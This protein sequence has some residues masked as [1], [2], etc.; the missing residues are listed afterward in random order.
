M[1]DKHLTIIRKTG[2]FLV[3]GIFAIIAFF[4]TAVIEQATLLD[5]SQEELKSII[6]W[7]NGYTL[8]LLISG[9]LLLVG[10]FPLHEVACMVFNFFG[11][12]EDVPEKWFTFVATVSFFAGS[13]Y[14]IVLFIF[15]IS[16][17]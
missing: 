1:E 7:I 6:A 16:R 14:L 8:H 3:S 12:K 17:F 15:Y 9:C 11:K 13:I 4:N 2:L 5:V 10:I